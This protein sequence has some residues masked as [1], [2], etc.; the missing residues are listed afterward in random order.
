MHWNKNRASSE[1][2]ESKRGGNVRTIKHYSI[3]KSDLIFCAFFLFCSGEKVNE[4][5]LC[6]KQHTGNSIMVMKVNKSLIRTQFTLC[7]SQFRFNLALA[8][9]HFSFHSVCM[10]L[11]V[12]VFS[13]A[14]SRCINFER[15]GGQLNTLCSKRNNATMNLMCI[16]FDDIK[17][18]HYQVS[19]ILIKCAT[20]WTKKN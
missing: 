1:L 13:L 17:T 3:N 11:A 16:V 20:M 2:I 12:C 18:I 10:C 7:C 6:G 8:T 4:Q 15:N 5:N 9:L 14:W 19:F